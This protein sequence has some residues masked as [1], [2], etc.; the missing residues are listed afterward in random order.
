M[1]KLLS[2]ITISDMNNKIVDKNAGHAHT[3]ITFRDLSFDIK[4]GNCL[5]S[6][7]DSLEMIII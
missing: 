5:K 1:M 6:F 4:L 2:L 3:G 7:T